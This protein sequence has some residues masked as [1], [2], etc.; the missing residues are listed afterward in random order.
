MAD[1]I[2]SGGRNPERI[3]VNQAY[4]LRDLVEKVRECRKGE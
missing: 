2:K 4:A 1:E 3:N